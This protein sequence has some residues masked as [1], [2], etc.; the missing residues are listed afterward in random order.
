M[1][2]TRLPAYPLLTFDPLLSIWSTTDK[3]YESVPTMWTG[4]DKP[5]NG[6]IIIDGSAYRFMGL[7]GADAVIPQVRVMVS[8]TATQYEF[9][10]SKVKLT[11]KFTRPLLPDDLPLASFPCAFIDVS[12]IS[13][14]G[15]EHNI[16]IIMDFG[17]KIAYDEGKKL[18]RSGRIPFENAKVVYLGR[19]LQRPLTTAGDHKE[20][21]WGWL[22]LTGNCDA[23]TAGASKMK[24]FFKKFQLPERNTNK[25]VLISRYTGKVSAGKSANFFNI[26]AFDD[27]ASINYFGIYK[28]GFWATR[29]YDFVN[30]LREIMNNRDDILNKT[31]EFDDATERDIIPRYGKEYMISL[32]AAYRQTFAGLKM[33]Y[34]GDELLCFSKECDSNGC[35]NTVDVSYPA[36]PLLLLTAP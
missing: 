2:E 15:E 7:K 30:A 26:I 18:T 21:D 12:C 5:M 14:D 33:V 23:L 36:S 32:I 19:A 16:L 1:I 25:K 27:M 24:K 9:K 28:N 11:V 29:Y 4:A 20:I 10:N 31:Q 17:E 35:M 6:N 34:D 3:L 22:Y 8:M 13:L